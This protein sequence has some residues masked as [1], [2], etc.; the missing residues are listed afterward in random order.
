MPARFSQ[1]DG[2]PEQGRQVFNDA[3]DPDVDDGELLS[4]GE[5]WTAD[6][7]AQVPARC[8]GEPRSTQVLLQKAQ[9]LPSCAS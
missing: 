7:L 6:V 3:I 1:A 4:D 5:D 9:C 8:G 2:A